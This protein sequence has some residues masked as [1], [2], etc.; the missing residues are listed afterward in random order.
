MPR[1]VLDGRVVERRPSLTERELRLYAEAG[2]VRADAEVWKSAGIE[3]YQAQGYRSAGL[4]LDN[5]VWCWEAGFGGTETAGMDRATLRSQVY[6]TIRR[7]ARLEE[8]YP[9][10]LSRLKPHHRRRVA[11]ALGQ[12]L[13]VDQAQAWIRARGPIDDMYAWAAS[14]SPPQRRDGCAP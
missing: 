14:G 11:D 4:A 10:V 7:L 6:A 5:A 13:A 3:P 2:L 8:G 1:P 9:N 12:G